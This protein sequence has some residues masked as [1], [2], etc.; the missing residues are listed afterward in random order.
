M[1]EPTKKGDLVNVRGTKYDPLHR[2]D[3]MTVQRTED[4]ARHSHHRPLT[5]PAWL[6][7]GQDSHMRP[8]DAVLGLVSE[9]AQYALPWWIMKN[10]HVANLVLDARPT[11]VVLCEACAGASAFDARI[12]GQRLN[13][14]V[15]GKYNGTH[16]LIDDETDSLWTPFNGVSRSGPM[17]G[18]R[19]E[20]VPLYQCTWHEWKTLYPETLVPDG[21]GESREGHGAIFPSPA[22]VG[23]IAFAKQTLV[24]F[25]DRLPWQMLVLGVET[26]NGS[27]AYPLKHLHGQGPVLCDRIGG[28]SIVVF[29][30]PRS[31]L[32]IAFDR[33]LDGRVLEFRHVA[34]TRRIED[35]GTA[36]QWDM[37]GRAVAGPLAGRSLRYVPSGIE[38][39]YAWS[40]AHPGAEIFKGAEIS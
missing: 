6:P 13:F 11:M 21:H 9:Q 23:R 1:T 30:K 12:D 33:T 31:W 35:T 5:S 39:W 10:H 24:H 19:L 32:A 15:E 25:D 37:G 40:A 18:R 34:G 4:G 27:K 7:A 36:T 29:S 26:A 2:L 8:D 17:S 3:K 16:I 20:Q 14:R 28:Q 38:K 22:R